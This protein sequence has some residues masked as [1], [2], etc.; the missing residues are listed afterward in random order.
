MAG[1]VLAG[2]L[3]H[4]LAELASE[5]R[6]IVKSGIQGDGRDRQIR[7]CE[8]GA[9]FDDAHPDHVFLR[10]HL[11]CGAEFSFKLANGHRCHGR[12]RSKVEFF[13]KMDFQMIGDRREFEVWLHCRALGFVTADGAAESTNRARAVK[14]RQLVGNKP[15][16]SPLGVGEQLDN[17]EQRI[18][19][20]DDPC[21]VLA[22]FFGEAR[23]KNGSI[24]DADK[25]ELGT[26]PA[27]LDE[28]RV[29][30]HQ[31][32]IDVFGKEQGSRQMV[33]QVAEL[34]CRK[35]FQPFPALLADS[36]LGG[37]IHNKSAILQ[38]VVG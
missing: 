17:S 7:L 3:T 25:L 32:T 2:S 37:M 14:E 22:V 13:A 20:G 34:S 1:P 29:A 26:E 5:V 23:R 16:G 33:E 19:G 15:L 30:R 8:Q 11:E 36:H 28:G 4:V 21:V 12:Q 38:A 31:P 24:G 9:R 6:V 27:A 35:F 10:R 18:S